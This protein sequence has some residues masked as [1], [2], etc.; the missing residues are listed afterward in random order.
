M[1]P[2]L[3]FHGYCGILL[4]DTMLTAV[5]EAQNLDEYFFFCYTKGEHKDGERTIG[6]QIAVI[7]KEAML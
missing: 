3:H 7:I 5:L 2:D 4:I 6:T 1:L